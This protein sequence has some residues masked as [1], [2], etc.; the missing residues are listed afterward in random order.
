MPDLTVGLQPRSNTLVSDLLR[1]AISAPLTFGAHAI[2]GMSLGL[3]DPTEEVSEILGEDIYQAA[4]KWARSGAEIVGEFAPVMGSLTAARKI[5]PGATML[6]RFMQGLMA[7][8]TL[9][10]IRGAVEGEGMA[11]HALTEGLIFGGIEALTGIP[12]MV[13]K[14]QLRR[15]FKRTEDMLPYETATVDAAVSPEA[16]SVAQDAEAFRYRTSPTPAT[17]A[18]TMKGPL[19]EAQLV[20][21]PGMKAAMEGIWTD[22]THGIYGQRMVMQLWDTAEKELR[23]VDGYIRK[24]DK[25]AVTFVE[26]GTGTEHRLTPSKLFNPVGSPDA[27]FFRGGRMTHI[28]PPNMDFEYRVAMKSYQDLLGRLRRSGQL[29]SIQREQFVQYVNPKAKSVNDLS[30]QEVNLLTRLMRR[31]AKGLPGEKILPD[32]LDDIVG[33]MGGEATVTRAG[34]WSWFQPAHWFV[35]AMTKKMGGVRWLKDV[36]KGFLYAGQMTKKTKVYVAE[37]FGVGR[38][39]GVQGTLEFKAEGMFRG[40]SEEQRNS[41]T[42]LVWRIR[43]ATSKFKKGEPK[44]VQ[45]RRLEIDK[46][47]TEISKRWGEATSYKL[48]A[49]HSRVM[50]YLDGLSDDLLRDALINLET[51]QKEL[52]PLISGSEVS[53]E[54]MYEGMKMPK[55]LEKFLDLPEMG[56]SEPDLFK[57]IDRAV[58]NY[59]NLKYQKPAWKFMQKQ[60]EGREVHKSLSDWLGHYAARQRGIPSKVDVMLAESLKTGFAK[61][62]KRIPWLSEYAHNFTVKD[63]LKISVFFNDLPYLAHLGLR[64]FSAMRNLL[65]PM[66]TTG[67]LIG[68]TWLAR[69]YHLFADPK[70]RGW[71]KAHRL[72]QESLGEYEMRL[73]L[74]PRKLDQFGKFMMHLFRKSDELN[75]YASGLGMRSKFDHFFKVNGMTEEF[76]TNI[77]LRRFRATTRKEVRQLKDAYKATDELIKYQYPKDSPRARELMAVVKRA[78]GRDKL[79][80]D[81]IVEKMRVKIVSEAIGNT[82]WLYGKEHAPIFT[83]AA[84]FPGRQMGVYQTW[85]LNYAEFMKNNIFTMPKKIGASRDYAPQAVWMANNLMITLG[86]LGLGWEADKIFRTVVFGPMPTELPLDPPGIQPFRHAAAAFANTF[87][88]FD[89]EAAEKNMGTALRRAWD[90]WVPG[91]LVYK[92]MS[93]VGWAPHQWFMGPTV[94]QAGDV[95]LTP[96][97]KYADLCAAAKA[98]SV[99]GGRG[100]G[101]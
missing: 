72:L 27:R 50:N 75:R 60:L 29:S 18:R 97:A 1:T 39:S 47:R 98:A 40:I 69:G 43:K 57:M 80:L 14:R 22:E 37:V 53:L 71:I 88:R 21:Q 17:I 64:P 35:E 41:I 100:R 90:N 19:P 55:Q 66:L 58:A 30:F 51:Y 77:K 11:Q 38:A 79:D 31:G 74:S 8:G 91:S 59:T 3:I 4:P 67:P 78:T 25:K 92:E 96:E 93:K 13:K 45:A 54:S 84:G 33:Y 70:A 94:L 12:A 101:E 2:K 62:P 61:V 65:Q 52:L 23:T 28:I 87:F 76:F 56:P 10:A 48:M 99:L 89:V 68:N 63:W 34:A 6:P 49:N 36:H 81:S 42:Q 24:I 82:Q 73:S 32:A 7:G 20:D 85:W 26:A 44:Y 86:F 9:G 5:I 46:W 83:H 95:K 15:L 16:H